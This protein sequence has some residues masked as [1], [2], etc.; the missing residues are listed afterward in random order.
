MRREF[1]VQQRVTN[2]K[3]SGFIEQKLNEKNYVKKRGISRTNQ[4]VECRKFRH[5]GR[6]FYFSKDLNSR[7]LNCM[8]QSDKYQIPNKIKACSM[9]KSDK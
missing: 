3:S 6:N 7:R 9:S 1:K 2:G 4:F 8:K 5:D